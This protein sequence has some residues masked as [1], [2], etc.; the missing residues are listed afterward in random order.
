MNRVTVDPAQRDV[1]YVTGQSIRRSTDGGKTLQFFKGAPG[2]DDYHFLWIN[3]KNPALMV[4]AAD[5]GTVVS[6]N[7]G[8][9]WSN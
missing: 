3:P 2:G 7:G 4:T 8:K 9:S 6:L 1:V 5:Q